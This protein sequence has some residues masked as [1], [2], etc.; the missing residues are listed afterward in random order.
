MKKRGVIV[1]IVLLFL[2]FNRQEEMVWN[3]AIKLSWRDFRGT[4][5]YNKKAAA[6][7]ASG[8]S[9]NLSATVIKKGAVAINY[10][11]KSFFYPNDSWY[12]KELANETVLLHEQLHFDI[13]ELHA[14][15]FRKILSERTFT[16]NVKAE[17]REIYASI[18]NE[19][20]TL[21]KQYDKATNYSIAKEKQ[22]EWVEI[23]RKELIKY[24][25]YQ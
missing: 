16:E 14:R 4:P 12:K 1:I 8:I 7:T 18:N 20:L 19:L 25:D 11:V 6:I 13:T 22:L 23:I 10:D 9:Y 24:K 15:K 2:S 21:Q 5:D 17:V 3:E